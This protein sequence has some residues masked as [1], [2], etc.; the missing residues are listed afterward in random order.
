MS[1]DVHF[2]AKYSGETELALGSRYGN[3]PAKSRGK[4]VTSQ[5]A[6]LRNAASR[7][8]GKKEK[9]KTLPALSSFLEWLGTSERPG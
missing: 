3:F 8:K 2:L 1:L 4:T 5:A 6:A 9:G 7:N